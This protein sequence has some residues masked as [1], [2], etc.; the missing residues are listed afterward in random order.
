MLALALVPQMGQIVLNMMLLIV[1]STI[2]RFETLKRVLATMQVQLLTSEL[3]TVAEKKSPDSGHRVLN[4]KRIPV[5]PL[6]RSPYLICILE[7]LLFCATI[8]NKRM[9]VG[10]AYAARKGRET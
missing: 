9:T 1:W 2:Y 7:M 6:P 10:A 4:D 5:R 8:W 3:S